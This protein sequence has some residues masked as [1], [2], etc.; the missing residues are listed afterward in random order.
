[1]PI[2]FGVGN[3]PVAKFVSRTIV[4]SFL[5]HFIITISDLPYSDILSSTD[6]KVIMHV[7][8]TNLVTEMF[9]TSNFMGIKRV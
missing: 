5:A 9:P 8:D 6:H 3:I 2:K 7:L 4:D 1:M